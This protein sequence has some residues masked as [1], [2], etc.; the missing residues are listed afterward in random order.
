MIVTGRDAARARRIA[1]RGA[2]VGDPP[3]SSTARL[4]SAPLAVAIFVATI[5]DDRLSSRW[6]NRATRRDDER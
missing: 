3:P 6:C 4:V 2:A 5:I 1:H